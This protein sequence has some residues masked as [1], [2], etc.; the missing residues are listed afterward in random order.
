M[1]RT[2]EIS[3]PL[4]KN[5]SDVYYT[6]H[7]I[8]LDGLESIDI[9][10]S[11]AVVL[12][13][14]RSYYSISKKTAF[15]LSAK[16]VGV[17]VNNIDDAIKEDCGDLKSIIDFEGKQYGFFN[18]EQIS[19]GALFDLDRLYKENDLISL[20]SIC[21]RPIKGKVVKGKYEIEEY[22]GYNPDTFNRIDLKTAESVLTFFQKSFQILKSFMDTSLEL[23]I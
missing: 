16:Q 20:M 11:S 9:N 14:L 19:L 23:G 7:K 12:L 4:Y 22:D 1:N 17:L 10:D 2:A 15:T 18:F 3:I 6:D 5:K 21:Y 8:F 13:I